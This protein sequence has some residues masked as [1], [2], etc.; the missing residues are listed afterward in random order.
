M[1]RW[2]IEDGGNSCCRIDFGPLFLG[3]RVA[4]YRRVSW[5]RLMDR[6]SA[7]IRQL[8]FESPALK[9]EFFSRCE[10]PRRLKLQP[11]T[12]SRAAYSFELKDLAID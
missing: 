5:N 1:G 12:R 8:G 3:K 7:I 4:T 9:L 2:K 11:C 6:G 10:E